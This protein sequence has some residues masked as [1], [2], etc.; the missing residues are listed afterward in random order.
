MPG[1]A[2][3]TVHALLVD[4]PREGLALP[5]L[6]ATA[7]ISEAEATDLYAAMIK[8]AVR[9]AA[10]SGGDLLV[11]SPPEDSLAEIHRRDRSPQ[12][13]LRA[14]ISEVIDPGEA[15]FEVQVGSTFAARAGNA[16]THLLREEDADSVAILDGTTPTLART[17]L[18]GAAMKLRRSEV[19]LGPAPGGRVHYLGLTEPLDFEGAYAPPEVETLARRGA[20]AG[21]DVDFLSL[22][23]RVETGADLVTLLATIRA[24]QA[25]G[26][27]VPE[28]TAAALS[29]LGV[30]IGVEDGERQIER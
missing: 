29:E 14:L 2:A 5:D 10:E 22:H 24:R 8:D 30:H 3:V 7:P 17:D 23:P 27:R 28:H 1:W 9:A 16:T 13:E 26:R 19:V 21:F 4:P 12:A 18:D 25:G 11:N 6:P 20:D 15:R